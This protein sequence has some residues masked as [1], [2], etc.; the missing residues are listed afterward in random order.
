VAAE[1]LTV[2]RQ[3]SERHSWELVARPPHR[4][5][6]EYV[7][8]DYRGYVEHSAAPLSRR[9]V[10]HGSVVVIIDLGGEPLTVSSPGRGPGATRRSFVAGLHTTY[11]RTEYDGVQHGIQIDMTPLGARMLFG[12]PMSELADRV[13]DL[14][15]LLGAEGTL[16]N[17]RLAEAREWNERFQILDAY[18]HARLAGAGLPPPSVE[19][20]W[21]RLLGRHG[22]VEIG[23]LAA[24]LRASRRH[25]IAQF[26]DQIG[27]P[28]KT[29]A[30]I[31]RFNRAVALL[32]DDD[33]SR[34]ADIAYECGYYDQA[35]F[36]RDFRQFAGT[37]PQQYL[38]SRLPTGLGFSAD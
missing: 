31:L 9:E 11:A 18:V 27:L 24:E 6:R 19:W 35:H 26:R 23:A 32:G 17:E 16:L 33:G 38:A 3:R 21:Q 22:L 37:A 5:L 12:L 15:D 34:L 20:A 1:G 25:L 7:H 30:R 36:N 2:Q 4:A 8:G 14:E 13:V 28:P 10:P 29:I